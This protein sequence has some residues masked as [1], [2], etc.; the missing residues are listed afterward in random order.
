MFLY[1]F[2]VKQLIT[3]C[4]YPISTGMILSPVSDFMVELFLN[5]GII[6]YFYVV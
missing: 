1:V 2:K 3:L 6:T 5:R 4:V